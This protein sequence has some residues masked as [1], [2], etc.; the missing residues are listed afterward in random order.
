M[1]DR[2]FKT[3][4]HGLGEVRMTRLEEKDRWARGFR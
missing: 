2:Y 3:D 4:V 1:W